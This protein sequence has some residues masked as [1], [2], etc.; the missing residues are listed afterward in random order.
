MGMTL[1]ASMNDMDVG[2][3]PSCSQLLFKSTPCGLKVNCPCGCAGKPFCWD[4]KRDWT[5]DKTCGNACC[6]SGKG[7]IQDIV[8]IL[9]SCP[10]TSLAGKASVPK[11]RA[12]PKCSMLI[13]HKEACQ[14]MTCGRNGH[15][16]SWVKKTGCKHQF[17]FVCLGNWSGHRSGACV[18]HP[19]QNINTLPKSAWSLH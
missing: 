13:E 18:N 4:C 16:G 19:P 8:A 17:C 6:S 15:A 12:C 5:G 14:H 3:C 1:R 11:L 2:N 7:P 10:T 9:Q